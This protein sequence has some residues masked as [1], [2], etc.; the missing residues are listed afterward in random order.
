MARPMRWRLSDWVLG[1]LTRA[2]EQDRLRDL[3]FIASLTVAIAAADYASGIQI[4]LAVFYLAPVLLATAWFGRRAGVIV[5]LASIA[6]RV[7]GDFASVERQALPFW[8]V[9][10]SISALLMFLFI[11]WVFSNLLTLYRGLEQRGAE[12]TV[13][14]ADEAARRVQLE[15]DLLM[16][17]ARERASMGQELHDDI[18][19]HLVGTAFAAKVL[20]QRLCR[21]DAALVTEGTEIVDLLEQGIRKT[22][23]LARGLMLDSI[24]PDALEERLSELAEEVTRAGVPSR[25]V[26]A[27]DV[28]LQ[29]AAMAAQV[30]RI[31]QEAMRNALRH[32]K[33]G[34][35]ELSLVADEEVACLTIDD[36]GRGLSTRDEASGMGL[37]I[38]AHRAASIGATLVLAPGTGRGTRWICRVP[39]AGN[40]T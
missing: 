30:Y 22:R 6:L 4:S 23:R 1:Q 32:A 7:L 16:I 39:L 25:F 19:Q 33:A 38:M 20:T 3:V 29:D 36:D 31:A 8:S 17:S 5:S 28:R 10:N 21:C 27:G 34:R 18:C 40:A 11:V 26:V 13:A 9:W 15:H 2:R 14:L 12:R 37:K 35:I 24:E